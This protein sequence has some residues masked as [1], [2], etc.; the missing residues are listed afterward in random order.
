R[1]K[2]RTLWISQGRRSMTDIKL[3]FTDDIKKILRNKLYFAYTY[4]EIKNSKQLIKKVEKDIEQG[5]TEED[6]GP[7]D[8]PDR[9]RALVFYPVN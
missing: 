1:Y 4:K 9:V 8:D 6:L 5:F 7:M 2:L 3:K